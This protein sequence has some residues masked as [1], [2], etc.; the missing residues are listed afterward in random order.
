MLIGVTV[1]AYITGTVSALL[2]SF[3]TQSKRVSEYQHQVESFCRSHNIPKA[4][5]EKLVQYY[6]Y[7][8]ARKVHPEDSQIISGLSGALR[9]QVCC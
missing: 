4:L 5:T 8:L 7:V 1:F 6:D 3:N 9:S 2:T